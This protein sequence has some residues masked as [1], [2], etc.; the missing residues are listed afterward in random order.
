M[1]IARTKKKN[2]SPSQVKTPIGEI[3]TILGGI[4]MGGSSKSLRKAYMREVN[5]IH[6]HLPSSKTP[7]RDDPDISFSERDA[8]GIRQPYD[9]PLVVMLRIEGYN[10]H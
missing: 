8:R 5:S 3:R 2:P 9:D 6:Y 4:M 10:I 7:R 1:E